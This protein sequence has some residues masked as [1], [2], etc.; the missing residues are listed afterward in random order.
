M[1]TYIVYIRSVLCCGV[2]CRLVPRLVVCVSARDRLFFLK[3]PLFESLSLLDCLLGRGYFY[4]RM[5]LVVFLRI[6]SF[7]PVRER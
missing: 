5:S 6:T 7:S 1:Y 4:V 2:R 3:F